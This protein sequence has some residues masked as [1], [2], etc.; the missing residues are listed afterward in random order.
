MTDTDTS[1]APS[2][3]VPTDLNYGYF[4]GDCPVKSENEFEDHEGGSLNSST[5]HSQFSVDAS[6]QQEQGKDKTEQESDSNS[7][8]SNSGGSSSSSSSSSSSNE[9]MEFVV[10]LRGLPWSCTKDDVV[11]FLGCETV[12]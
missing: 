7:S 3:A 9:Q 5:H 2:S 8:E 6:E 11:D 10:K 1:S 12:N 4:I